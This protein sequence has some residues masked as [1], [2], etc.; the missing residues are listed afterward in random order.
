MIYDNSNITTTLDVEYYEPHILNYSKACCVNLTFIRISKN[1][2]QKK[3]RI[4]KD[5]FE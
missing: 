5:D 3:Y 1:R 4:T 2:F